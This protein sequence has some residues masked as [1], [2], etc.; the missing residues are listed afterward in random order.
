MDV[1][2]AADVVASSSIRLKKK[3]RVFFI[4]ACKKKLIFVSIASLYVISR[5]R[6]RNFFRSPRVD[7]YIFRM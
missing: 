1:T 2:A 7:T 6:E 3:T 5:H 4:L